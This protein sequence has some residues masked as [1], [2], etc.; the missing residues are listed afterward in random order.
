MPEIIHVDFEEGAILHREVTPQPN[1]H[2]RRLAI[3]GGLAVSGLFLYTFGG[4]A[5]EREDG[6]APTAEHTAPCEF[7]G[8]TDGAVVGSMSELVLKIDG[9][10]YGSECYDEA[11]QYVLDLNG[12]LSTGAIQ[13][14]VE[15]EYPTNLEPATN[16]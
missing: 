6:S 11:T 7:S 2:A 3:A 8:E 5:L 14:G 9:I 10:N 12:L 4:A 15:Y 13:A 1:K 16:D